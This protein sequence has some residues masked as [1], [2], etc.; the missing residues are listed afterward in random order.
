MLTLATVL[1]MF[2]GLL[3]VIAAPLSGPLGE[4]LRAYAGKAFAGAILLVVIGSIIAQ[5]PRF[6]RLAILIGACLAA[7]IIVELR[8][9]LGLPSRHSRP[10]FTNYRRSG[11]VPV[12]D[13]TRDDAHQ[14]L[15]HD[16]EEH[17][18]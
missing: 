7:F 9:R 2:A 11:K 15:E 10:T 6:V 16:D 1:I 4:Q 18:W 8:M 12:T 14:L 17:L 5:T 13:Q 3:L